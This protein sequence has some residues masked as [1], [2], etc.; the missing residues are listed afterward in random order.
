MRLRIVVVLLLA[1]A[2]VLAVAG[3]Q[4]IKTKIG[5]G[6][7]ISNPEAGTPEKVIQD[8]LKAARMSDDNDGW[9]AFSTLL[10]SQET[11]SPAAMNKWQTMVYPTMRRKADFLLVDKSALIY[12]LMDK[13][14]EGKDVK[15]YVEN[16]Q[17][18]MPTPC[19]LRRD[20]E[21]GNAWRVFNACF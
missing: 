1:G 17:S 9:Q 7:T 16:S 2:F 12:K 19:T 5:I 4:K 10:H 18:D 3:C 8:V 21:Q 20:P 14:E 15:V 13:R 6:E 11:S